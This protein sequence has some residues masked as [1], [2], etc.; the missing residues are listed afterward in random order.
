MIRQ[1]RPY[2]Y[3]HWDANWTLR[4]VGATAVFAASALASAYGATLSLDEVRRAERS[5]QA[6][7][8]ELQLLAEYAAFMAHETAQIRQDVISVS[9]PRSRPADPRAKTRAALLRGDTL[10]DLLTVELADLRSAREEARERQCLAE[11]I[12][13][14]AR[15][16]KR[17][18]QLAV[19][20][21][22][23]NRVKSSIYPDS[24]CDVVY[25]GSERETGCQFSFT[26]DGSM[27][28]AQLTAR[29]RRWRDAQDMAGSI[30]AGL[31]KPVSRYATHYHAD[32]VDPPWAENL[33]PTA[34]IGT[35][36]FYRFKNRS[37]NFA[38][39]AGM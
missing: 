6:E 33:Q 27:N 11:A 37:V 7:A 2:A 22:I 34:T 16:E 30:M 8:T 39:P 15:S 21:V 29:N 13:F 32:Y 23:L 1:N 31:H 35:H 19:A 25:Q 4:S 5:Q 17:V 38:A 12:Y 28:S 20:D 26:C 36:K 10:S 18:G 24:I 9:A 14:E 3:R